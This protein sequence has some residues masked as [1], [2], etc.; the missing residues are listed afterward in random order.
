[1]Q[2]SPGK[3]RAEHGSQ[4]RAVFYP[5]SAA[6]ELCAPWGHPGHVAGN[7]P[8]V[9]L[10]ECLKVP[11][12]FLPPR[13]HEAV[14]LCV[15]GHKKELAD[16]T[17]G[18]FIGKVW[19]NRVNYRTNVS[20]WGPK[21]PFKDW[22]SKNLQHLPAYRDSGASR[23]WAQGC[24][25]SCLRVSPCK[26]RAGSPV[27]ETCPVSKAEWGTWTKSRLSFLRRED[28]GTDWE[29]AVHEDKIHYGPTA[30]H[31]AAEAGDVA[32]SFTWNY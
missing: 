18:Y 30:C 13:Q 1:M 11:Y 29:L 12:G 28:P 20:K 26:A 6:A 5:S 25:T 10:N 27:L 14:P 23:A 22:P 2:L 15:T 3:V 8:R 7:L 21:I 19:K 32:Q 17:D 4:E 24:V 9:M 16:G 31:R